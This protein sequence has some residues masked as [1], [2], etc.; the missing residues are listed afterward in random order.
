MTAPSVFS[1]R[2]LAPLGRIEDA[3]LPTVATPPV[4]G[5]EIDPDTPPLHLLLS[6]WREVTA[7]GL[8]IGGWGIDRAELILVYIAELEERCERL[9]STIQFNRERHAEEIAE[10]RARALREAGGDA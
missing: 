8:T 7:K 1:V 5:G 4:E 10:H 6:H 3:A 9:S 2:A